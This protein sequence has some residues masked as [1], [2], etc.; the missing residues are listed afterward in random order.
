MF[1]TFVPLYLTFKQLAHDPTS[2]KQERR[3]RRR[4]ERQGKR[5]RDQIVTLKNKSN[6]ESLMYTKSQRYEP[7]LRERERE[8]KGGHQLLTLILNL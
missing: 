1:P 5:G 4:R 8:R 2:P 3:R 7:I 6:L